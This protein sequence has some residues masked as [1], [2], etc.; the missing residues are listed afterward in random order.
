MAE[1]FKSEQQTDRHPVVRACRRLADFY[2]N[3]YHRVQVLNACPIPRDGPAVLVSNHISGLD[4]V[5][6]QYACPRLVMW[7]MAREYYEMRSMRWFFELVDVIPVERSGR[8]LGATRTA[9]RALRRG[10]V[11]GLFPEGRISLTGQIE[12]LQT[13][14]AML[15]IR[16][17]APVYPMYID[18]SVRYRDMLEAY[19][20]PAQAT[21]LFGPAVDIDRSDNSRETLENASLR[22]QE[23]LARLQQTSQ[24]YHAV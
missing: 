12:P 4:P 9:L 2:I 11:V 14:A 15:A 6:I 23:A 20:V 5:L 24:R 7:M 1:T 8:D 3:G 18:G 22:I 16:A 13:G 21:V 19:L 17:E 10:R